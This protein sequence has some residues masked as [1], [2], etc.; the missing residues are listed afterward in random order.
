MPFVLCTTLRLLDHF[1]YS[2]DCGGKTEAVER[3]IFALLL[4]SDLGIN[5]E[6]PMSVDRTGT[7]I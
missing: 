5:S 7:G 3:G 1:I 2:A 4:T 6:K